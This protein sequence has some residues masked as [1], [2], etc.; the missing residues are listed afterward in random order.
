[1]A[2]IDQIMVD[3]STLYELVP[4]IAPLFDNTKA[5]AVGD[6][7]I[8]DA[9]L[10]R[11]TAAHAA[12][13]WVGTD[14]EEITVGEELT[15][16]KADLQDIEGE[17]AYL[18]LSEDVKQALLQIAEKVAY[19]DEHGQDYY[20]A[21]KDALYLP[22]GLVSI[23]A[24]YTQSEK[25]YPSTPLTQLKS[26]LV[27]R[28][29]YENGT[30]KVITDYTMN[31]SLEEGTSTITVAY[32]RKTATFTVNVSAEPYTITNNLTNCANSNT[33]VS[34]N[35]GESYTATI[36]AAYGCYVDDTYITV[37]MGGND[38][39]STVLN[40]RVITIS[41]VT[42]NIIIT[43]N[44]ANALHPL[45][46]G[47]HTFNNGCTITVTNGNHVEITSSHA[48][49]GSGL[50]NFSDVTENTDT[51]QIIDNV[52]NNSK[53]F[54]INAGQTAVFTIYNYHSNRQNSFNVYGLGTSGA[55]DMAIP[56]LRASTGSNTKTF[57]ESADV[58]CLF[59]AITQ[60]NASP[61]SFDVSLVVDGVQYV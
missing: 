31:G 45:K 47:T 42:G 26:N 48:S 60:Y 10:Y 56:D 58:G 52:Q 28:A 8:K 7:V 50:V 40:D 20:D 17:I 4:E 35:P 25:V 37:L 36:T 12:G 38:V 22:V 59:I 18:G 27:V 15:D 21:L 54:T 32:Y 11:F 55:L 57:A 6:C 9:V 16:L 46:N 39:T 49:G 14:A 51:E 43:A 30:S 1:M 24:V 3:D 13:A 44:A 41:E 2:K 23:S 19:V 29:R 34:V 53:K 5:Y 61:I 33:A